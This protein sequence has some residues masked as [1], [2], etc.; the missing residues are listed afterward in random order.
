MICFFIAAFI[1]CIIITP[2]V[3]INY[4][5]N[6]YLPEESI[7]TVS[8]D[9]MLEEF[10]G[11]IPNARLMINDVSVPEALDYKKRLLEIEGVLEVTWLDDA[12][13]IYT[14]LEFMDG[15]IVRNWYKDG[16]ALFTM[17]IE[18]ENRIET[19][20]AIRD[21]IGSKG[22]LT[23]SAITLAL[24]ATSASA[25]MGIVAVIAIAFSLFMLMMTTSSWIAPL[26]VM[27]GLGVAIIVN[28]G[29]HIIFGEV[30]FVTDAAGTVL[31]LAVSMDYSVFLLHRFD[32][33]KKKHRD[34][35]DAMVEAL[36]KSSSSILS[37]G[38]TTAIGFLAL[39]FMRFSI[40]P[41][42]GLALAKGIVI[43]LLTVFLFFPA[44]VMCTDKLMSKTRHRPFMPNMHGFG[45]VV[46]RLMMPMV[47]IFVL[48]VAPAWLASVN[49]SFDFGAANFFGPDTQLGADSV[50]IN[51][52]YG[53]DDTYVLLVPKGDAPTEF[54][55]S[56]KLKAIPEVTDIVSYVDNVGAEIPPAF[57]DDSVLSLLESD[58]FSRM[59]IS[60]DSE[61]DDLESFALIEAVREV[62]DG[63]YG[64]TYYLAGESISTYDLR[65]IVMLDMIKVNLV[66]IGA[67][68]L[69]LLL[70]MKSLSLPIL[71]VLSIE[72]AVWINVSV[73]YFTDK[74]IFYIA[75]LMIS[76]IQLGATVDYAIL[77]TNRF[78]ECRAVMDKK[79]AVVET[80][81]KVTASILT[82][83]GALTAVGLLQGYFS[84]H[85]L[86]SQLGYFIGRGTL[87][88]L[89]LVFF[90]LP[91]LLYYCDGIIRRTTLGLH[92]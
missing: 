83:G 21:L 82:S 48:I 65:E 31:L 13:D 76:A 85:G 29:T 49:N 39:C 89:V 6:E 69:V 46:A 45:R 28:G 55:L 42:L 32:E 18:A 57:V 90:V 7:S 63:Y 72:T 2:F 60:V 80:V 30:S 12:V 54:K 52:K 24:T 40:G 33:C 92:K 53:R 58:N 64:D 20:D 88:T 9:K 59:I 91:G 10:S 38:M 34:P 17:V 15:D 1:T 56:E 86:L 44:V 8:L 79:T 26:V 27:S 4:D 66:A 70:T 61:Y 81:S 5:M 67:V 36:K 35:R 25:E 47:V 71:M 41:D 16:V 50:A 75:Y 78:I 3:S 14:P 62:A 19:I 37:S 22:S 74:P 23:G 43:S 73:P 11:D 77:L 84:T 51:E 87:C 68:F